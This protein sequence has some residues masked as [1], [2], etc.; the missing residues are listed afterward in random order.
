MIKIVERDILE[1]KY[2]EV[3]NSYLN[4]LKHEFDIAL[5]PEHWGKHYY[6]YEGLVHEIR[7]EEGQVVDETFEAWS[8]EE[9]NF[10]VNI[11][12]KRRY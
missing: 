2:N 6:M 3:V 11:L 7:L 5:F 8:I 10:T 4:E 9:K 1:E 12:D